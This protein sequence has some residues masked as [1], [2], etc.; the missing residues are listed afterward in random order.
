MWSPQ[1]TRFTLS[2]SQAFRRQK[3]IQDMITWIFLA[4]AHKLLS[5]S[6]LGNM[7]LHPRCRLDNQRI[8]LAFRRLYSAELR[9]LSSS[10]LKSTVNKPLLFSILTNFFLSEA[11]IHMLLLFLEPFLDLP[12]LH[13]VSLYRSKKHVLGNLFIYLFIYFNPVK[14]I[15]TY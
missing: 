10:L 7:A 9:C 15:N 11:S 14:G 3:S 4:N 12:S 6:D 8:Y 5:L 13:R 2:L 1:G